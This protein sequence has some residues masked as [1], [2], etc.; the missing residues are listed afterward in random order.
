MTSFAALLALLLLSPFVP[1][2]PQ[3]ARRAITHEDV[4]TMARTG[5]PVVSPDG[6]WILYNVTE[7]SYDP[8]AAVTDLWIVAP[9]GRSKPR[10]L[11]STREAE[12]GAAWSPDSRWIAFAAKRASDQAEQ[13]YV[14][15]VDGGDAR[16]VTSIA[17]GAFAPRWRPDGTALLFESPVKPAGAGADKSTA[18]VF[19]AMP[20]RFWN[21]WLDGSKPHVFVQPIDGGTAEDW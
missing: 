19:D 11:T 12:S 14:I 15:G 10:R 16:R 9:D 6:R 21:A 2:A 3:T 20:I 8:S 18:R 7:P 13:I 17:T 5:R 1:S 4:Y